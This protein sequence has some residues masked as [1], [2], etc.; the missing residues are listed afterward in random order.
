MDVTFIIFPL[1]PYVLLNIQ[2]DGIRCV[3]I[4][5]FSQ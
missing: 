4:S 3:I 2:N 5:D 1:S